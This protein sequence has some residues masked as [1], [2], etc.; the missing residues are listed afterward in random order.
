M[1]SL[2]GERGRVPQPNSG[3][4]G[5]RP[6]S[7]ASRLEYGLPG[8]NRTRHAKKGSLRRLR[9][10]Q[11]SGRRGARDKAWT[12]LV[13]D[14]DC[15]ALARGQHPVALRPGRGSAF[16]C[17]LLCR[18]LPADDAEVP[19]QLPS[20]LRGRKVPVVDDYEVNQRVVTER[21]RLLGV[22]PVSVADGIE[23]IEQ[24]LADA[25]FA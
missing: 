22:E 23:L 14:A 8:R 1:V 3:G 24:Q 9:C 10:R 11:R 18:A 19:L 5:E 2:A 17:P 21:L 25:T 12:T 7:S 4:C 16:R 6:K 20:R 15:C 13:P